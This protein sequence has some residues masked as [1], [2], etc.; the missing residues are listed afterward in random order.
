M[1][2]KSVR[3]SE[4]RFLRRIHAGCVL[5]EIG[6]KKISNGILAVTLICKVENIKSNHSAKTK[7]FSFH[8][9]NRAERFLTPEFVFDF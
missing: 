7:A 9:C 8:I 4:L 3:G 6:A 2:E 1:T 5:E